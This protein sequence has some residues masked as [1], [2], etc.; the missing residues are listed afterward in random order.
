[1]KQVSKIWQLKLGLYSY[2]SQFDVSDIICPYCQGF[3]RIAHTQ[4]I[5]YDHADK[6]EHMSTHQID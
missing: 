3:G 2:E 1:M 6:S 5:I 4:H